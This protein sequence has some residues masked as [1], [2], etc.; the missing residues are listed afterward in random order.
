MPAI[1]IGL[2]NNL[3]IFSFSSVLFLMHS[4]VSADEIISSPNKTNVN[5]HAYSK[6]N[7]K[8]HVNGVEQ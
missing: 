6:V 2:N 5:T 1:K 3:N 8:I 7:F 4:V